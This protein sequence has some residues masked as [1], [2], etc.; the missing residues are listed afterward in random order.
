[1]KIIRAVVAGCVVFGAGLSL[2]DDNVRI[3][4]HSGYPMPGTSMEKGLVEIK[5]LSSDRPEVPG[6]VD[7][8]FDV[9]RKA[10]DD[11]HAV[12]D[13]APPPPLHVPMVRVEISLSDRRHM[14]EAGWSARGPEI[15][16]N[17]SENDRRHFAALETIV[18]ASVEHLS[19]TWKAGAK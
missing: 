15:P 19:L 18:R 10:L 6:E 3:M 1:M 7:R 4:F 8:Y 11:A 9:V 12:P 5:R 14:L 16:L 17:A 13:W 2:A